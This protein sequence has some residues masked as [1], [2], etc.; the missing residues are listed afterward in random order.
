MKKV[1]VRSA[2][3]EFELKDQPIPEPGRGCV[4]VKVQAC[5]RLS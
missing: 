2:R 4:R 1:N 3:G 5:G